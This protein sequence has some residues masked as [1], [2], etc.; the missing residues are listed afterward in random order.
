MLFFHPVLTKKV[1]FFAILRVSDMAMG[2][3]FDFIL[4]E[5][6]GVSS[7]RLN[8]MHGLEPTFVALVC[9]KSL[10]I[11]FFPEKSCPLVHYASLLYYGP[12]GV[13]NCVNLV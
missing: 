5:R 10:L 2:P 11:S 13:T 6:E 9:L 1:H 12:P 3:S 8:K 7:R 4:H